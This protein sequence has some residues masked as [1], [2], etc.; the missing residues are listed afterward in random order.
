MFWR[1][2][3]SVEK[4]GTVFVGIKGTDEMNFFDNIVGDMVMIF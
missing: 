1:T 3:Y 2:Y 4:C